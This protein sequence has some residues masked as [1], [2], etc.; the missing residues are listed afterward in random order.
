MKQ[1]S[2]IQD[3]STRTTNSWQLVYPTLHRKNHLQPTQASNSGYHSRSE[4]PLLL[5]QSLHYWLPSQ[6]TALNSSPFFLAWHPCSIQL[7]Q[8]THSSIQ[9]PTLRTYYLLS[10]LLLL[11]SLTPLALPHF[12][13]FLDPF[14]LHDETDIPRASSYLLCYPHW[15]S[16]H[17][18][19]LP[20]VLWS[21][22]SLHIPTAASS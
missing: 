17:P 19:N 4:W 20:T 10:S 6:L 5:R 16:F 14:H 2:Q 12:R 9:L 8:S 13:P 1:E 7:P 15:D 22:S 21:L 11:L 18:H 3:L